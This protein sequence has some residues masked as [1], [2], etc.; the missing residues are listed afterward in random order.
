MKQK[1]FNNFYQIL[2]IILLIIGLIISYILAEIDDA[3]GLI[4]IGLL[5]FSFLSSVLYGLGTVINQQKINQ[6]ILT[7]MLK[8]INNQ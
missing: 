6:E 7:K 2:A 3:P 4:I 5:F 8:K 1:K